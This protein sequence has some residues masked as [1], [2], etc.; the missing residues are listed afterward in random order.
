MSPGGITLVQAD[1]LSEELDT[2][3]YK[4]AVRADGQ[5]DVVIQVDTRSLTVET[6]YDGDGIVVEADYSEGKLAL[7]DP[8]GYKALKKAW[9][10]V[11][12][13]VLLRHRDDAENSDE[14]WEEIFAGVFTKVVDDAGEICVA[15][16]MAD[17][18][19]PNPL[20]VDVQEDTDD[21]TRM[22]VIVAS[23]NDE[24][25]PVTIDWGNGSP[26][27]SNPGDGASGSQY[28]YPSP[29]TYTITA[30]SDSDPE[31]RVAT[32]VVTLP[33]GS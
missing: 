13:L 18:V 2:V 4:V 9:P 24:Q 23:N 6:A 5:E 29:G 33:Y 10:G 26:T 28:Q 20:T 11:D 8:A 16:H 21:T 15:A 27:A 32:Q 14:E 17:V 31:G 30:T 22:S 12:E 1:T 25:G 3:C 19:P 7:Y